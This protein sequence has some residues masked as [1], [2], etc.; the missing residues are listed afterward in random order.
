[1]IYK[2]ALEGLILLAVVHE[3]QELDHHS[4]HYRADTTEL[5]RIITGYLK[6]KDPEDK[7]EGSYWRAVLREPDIVRLLASP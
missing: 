2:H 6:A 5:C 4:E 1:M 7:I 3:R